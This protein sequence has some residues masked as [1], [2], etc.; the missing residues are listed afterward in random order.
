MSRINKILNSIKETI[1]GTKKNQNSA[2]STLYTYECLKCGLT[3]QYDRLKSNYKCPI[4]GSTLY[5][6]F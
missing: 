1:S 5:R 2:K 6:T 4:D 3:I